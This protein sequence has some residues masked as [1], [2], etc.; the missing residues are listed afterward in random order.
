ISVSAETDLCDA[1]VT[2][3][4]PVID[5]F[6]VES[7][8]VS[9]QIDGGASVSVTPP[10]A[11]GTVTTL[12]PLTERFEVGPHTVTWTIVDASGNV[13]TCD[14]NITVTDDQLPT[15]TCPPNVEDEITDGGCDMISDAIAEPEFY[16]NCPDS[17]LS[18]QLTFEDGTTSAIITGSASGYNFPVGKTQVRYIVTDASGNQAECS[19]QVWIKNIADPQFTVTCP[20]NTASNISVSAET[21]L[22][23]AEVT[24][25]A[26]VIDNFCV[27]NFTVSYQ[28]DGGAS[29]SVT[30][31]AAVGTVTTLLPLTERFEVGPHTVTWTIVDASGNVYTCDINITVTDDQLPT[32]TCPPNVEDEITDGGCDMISDEIAEPEFYDNCPD[33]TLSYQLTFE[34]GTTSAIIDGSASGYNF[35]VGKTQVRY[36]VTDASGNQAECSFQVWIKNIADPQFTVTCPDNTASNISVSAETDLCDAEVTVPAPVIDNFCVESFTVSYQIDGGA[37]VSVTPPAA[38]GTVTTLLPLT[39][40]FEVGPHTVTW[41][42]VDA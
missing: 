23:D 35:P 37:S 36:I 26:P 21:D 16:D 41:T 4:A 3:P 2:V 29:V 10:A 38:V 34:D 39:E 28:I 27:E 42:I 17:T 12:L 32:I 13:Y 25:P 22:C 5:N 1:E 11:V 18:Y 7:F 20:D 19:F 15:I 6:C 40:R 9:Y 30:P 8:T 31:P 33:S 24:V 14:I